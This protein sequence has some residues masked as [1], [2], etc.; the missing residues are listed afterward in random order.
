MT[1][2]EGEKA[3][4]VTDGASTSLE[5]GLVESTT[6]GLFDVVGKVEAVLGT[7]RCF[8]CLSSS[9]GSSMRSTRSRMY[10][11]EGPLFK[12]TR[13]NVQ[14][15]L[16]FEQLLHIFVTLRSVVRYLASQRIFLR[17]HESQAR[18]TLDL[19]RGTISAF[20]SSVE[21][22]S[23]SGAFITTVSSDAMLKTK[24]LRLGVV[25]TFFWMKGS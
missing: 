15:S 8:S 20:W 13:E 19:F 21:V 25:G 3:L 6:E 24:L 23:T 11:F 5:R 7:E 1:N 10:P 16:F 17:R 4:F 9:C 14:N 12:G 18:E 22:S 2:P